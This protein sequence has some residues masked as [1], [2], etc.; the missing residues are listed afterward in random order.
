MSEK[1]LK[2]NTFTE[3]VEFDNMK[4]CAAEDWEQLTGKG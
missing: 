3:V 1:N 2:S 4:V